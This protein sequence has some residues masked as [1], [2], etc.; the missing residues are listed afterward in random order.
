MGAVHLSGPVQIL[1]TSLIV[2]ETLANY[3]VESTLASQSRLNGRMNGRCT[4]PLLLSWR[5]DERPIQATLL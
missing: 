1:R 2:G 5:L 3:G 4:W